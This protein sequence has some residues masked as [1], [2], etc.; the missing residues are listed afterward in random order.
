[1]LGPSLETDFRRRIG[2][3]LTHLLEE[4]PKKTG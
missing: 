2:K 1:M 4:V 3:V